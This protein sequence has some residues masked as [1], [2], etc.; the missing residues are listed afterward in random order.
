MLGKTNITMVEGGAIVSDVKDYS[1]DKVRVEGVTG[2]FVRAIYENDA[3]VAITKDG[4]V[5]Y[6]RDGENWS[7]VRLE[8]EGTYE[9]TDIIWDGRYYVMVGNC[10]EIIDQ[11]FVYHG[12]I[13]VTENLTDFNIIYES[14]ANRYIRYHAV[15]EQ[16]GKYTVISEEHGNKYNQDGHYVK[17]LIG[18]IENWENC[19]RYTI[20]MITEGKAY[21]R[22]KIIVG[23]NAHSGMIYEEYKNEFAELKTIEL[24]TMDWKIFNSITN[25]NQ[26]KILST[27]ECKGILYCF[28]DNS[29]YNLIKLD[30][31]LE[32]TQW[33]VMNVPFTDA[34]YYD[35]CEIFLTEFGLVI[36]RKEEYLQEKTLEDLIEITYDFSMQYIVKA[37]N[38]LYILGTGGNILKSNNEVNNEEALAVK[39]MSASKALYDARLYTDE[40]YNALEARIAALETVVTEL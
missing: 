37:F 12:F 5:A 31:Q 15:I 23:K 14:A 3:L 7:K 33:K 24:V 18:M 19:V 21:N 32:R 22:C 11:S 8:I 4:M 26:D 17:A 28:T 1:W 40:K 13:A 35:K 38:R 10:E 34:V 27:F 20:N 36:V 39:T 16:D 30:R 6:T 25:R 9:L 2:T 29:A